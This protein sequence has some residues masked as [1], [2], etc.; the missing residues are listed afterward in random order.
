LNQVYFVTQGGTYA[1]G[2]TVPVQGLSVGSQTQHVNGDVLTWV[3]APPF[4]APTVTV[5]TYGGKDGLVD[6]GDAE[7]IETARARYMVAV[8]APMGGGN[9]AQI[10]NVANEAYPGIQA[11]T[12]YAA[13]NGPS[14]VHVACFA[15]ATNLAASNARNR[16]VSSSIMTGTVAP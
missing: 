16:D 13:A 15:Y 12:V 8:S 6:G 1:S 11:S 10:A 3:V 5:G 7:D 9:N 2:S 4:C 14:T